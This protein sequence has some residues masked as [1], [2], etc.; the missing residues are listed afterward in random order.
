TIECGIRA[1]YAHFMGGLIRHDYLL[2]VPAYTV[3]CLF[4]QQR[5]LH[6][7]LVLDEKYSAQ[8]VSLGF[9]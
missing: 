7:I 6:R 5:T 1:L 9:S 4:K 2:L 8:S 3:I